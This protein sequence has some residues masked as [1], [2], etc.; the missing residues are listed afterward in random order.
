MG[1]VGRE[2]EESLAA[3]TAGCRGRG[4][5]IGDGDGEKLD[6]R[7]ELRYG[8]GDCGLLGAGAET[9]AGVFDVAAGD[10]D[11]GVRLGEEK[12]GSNVEVA[13]GSVGV[14]GCLE[15][16]PAKIEGQRGREKWLDGWR[17]L[18]HAV[19]RLR[20]GRQP[21]Q[22]SD[23]AGEAVSYSGVARIQ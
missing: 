6:G 12:G 23:C 17:S 21:R 8:G 18:R 2:L 14:L 13:V 7:A 19:P 1:G 15:G 11:A 16:A 3:G 9:V 4:V 20:A 22:G 5:A 10:H